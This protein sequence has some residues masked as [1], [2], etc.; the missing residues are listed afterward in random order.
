MEINDILDNCEYVV[1]NSKYVKIN[2]ENLLSITELLDTSN[3]H[4]LKSSPFGLLDLSLKDL[5]NFL[6]IYHGIGYCYWGNPKWRIKTKKEIIDGSFALIYL[7]KKNID[8]YNNFLDFSKLK[9]WDF[10]VFKEFLKGES[11]LSLLKERYNNFIAISKI[12]SE[13]FNNDFYSYI[14]DINSD[15]EL[16]D[17]IIKNFSAYIDYRKYKGNEIFFYKRA[18]LVVSDILHIKEIKENIVCDYSNLIGCADYKIPQILREF[19]VLE[20][21]KELSEKIENRT[22]LLENSEEEI[23]IRANTI[24]AINEIKK[25]FKGVSSIEINDMI[26]WLSQTKKAK[27]PYHLTIT[28]S[29]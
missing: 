8:K 25:L 15:I 18:Q 28:T 23:E 22:I 3:V 17:I 29:Y 13:K 1:N 24:V 11:E 21:N 2:K 7:F 4:W 12:V 20:Y 27:K 5:V 6:L 19:G 10:N 14:K 26:W 9:N 16:F